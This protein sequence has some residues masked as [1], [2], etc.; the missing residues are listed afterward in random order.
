M[1]NPPTTLLV[2]S[3]KHLQDLTISHNLYCYHYQNL[4]RLS[5]GLL[6]GRPGIP[7]TNCSN[8]VDLWKINQI[9]SFLFSKPYKSSAFHLGWNQISSNVYIICLLFQLCCSQANSLAFTRAYSLLRVFV[10][11]LPSTWAIL[12]PHH[13]TVHFLSLFR[14][15]LSVRP[16]MTSFFKV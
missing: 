8:Q 2:V 9:T 11:T 5:S 14:S 15:F 6:Q 13:F 4:H 7:L 16:S 12:L 3:V 10:F 1:A